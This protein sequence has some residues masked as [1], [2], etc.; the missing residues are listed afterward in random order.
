MTRELKVWEYHGKKVRCELDPA[1]MF[2][3]SNE[4]LTSLQQQEKFLLGVAIRHKE[5][6]HP[7]CDHLSNQL[8]ACVE[9]V[10]DVGGY[11]PNTYKCPKCGT[12]MKVIVPLFA[13][14]TPWL[15]GK[16]EK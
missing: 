4:M 16:I 14:G 3:Y 5:C 11:E 6:I 8:E 12:P 1:K 2:A 13:T 10:Y 9:E 15:W 7:D